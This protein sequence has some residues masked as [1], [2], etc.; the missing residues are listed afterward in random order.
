MPLTFGRK[1]QAAQRSCCRRPATSASRTS[2]VLPPLDRTRS[3]LQSRK[4]VAGYKGGERILGHRLPDWT[5]VAEL[6]PY[7]RE[8]VPSS[9]LARRAASAS[10]WSAATLLFTSACSWEICACSWRRWQ[11]RK[12]GH[13]CVLP[14]VNISLK[15][16]PRY[17]FSAT[18]LLNVA[19]TR[20]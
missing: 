16:R 15:H 13:L 9:S 19:F 18:Y 12:R 20:F 7:F 10:C 17:L 8:T 2:S 5:T 3:Y 14:A 4:N 11:E 1:L 6:K